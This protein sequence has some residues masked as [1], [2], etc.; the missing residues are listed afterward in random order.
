VRRAGD[1]RRVEGVW[2]SGPEAARS[3]G[4]AVI[5][6]AGGFQANPEM[7][8]A[9]ISPATPT[10][11]KVRGTKPR[12]RQVVRML[13]DLGGAAAGH[14]QVGPYVADRRGRA[15]L[16][17][18]ADEMA[19]QHPEPLRLSVRYHRDALGLRSSTKARRSIPTRMPRP[20]APCWGNRAPPP[21]I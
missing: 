2:W 11:M 15:R 5:A 20:A 16:R 19:R 9:P 7:R 3:Q 21:Q 12:Q 10:L 4:Q 1:L 6:C 13:L 8:R 14:W 17:D 18:S